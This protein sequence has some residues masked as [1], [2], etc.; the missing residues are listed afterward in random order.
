MAEQTIK[1]PAGKNREQRIRDPIVAAGLALFA[2]HPV[3]AVSID[4]I[5]G[6]AG[7]AKGSFYNHFANKEALL[8]A[9]VREIRDGIERDVAAANIEITDAARRV[10]RAICVYLRYVA[11]EPERGSVLVRNDRNGQTYASMSLSQG[12]LD[13]V[14]LG[15]R[16]GRFIVPTVDAGALFVLGVAHAGLMRFNGERVLG[17]NI[18][19][20]QQLCQ[21]ALRG[22]GVPLA[23]AELLSAQA[24][25][26]LLRPRA[27]S[28]SAQYTPRSGKP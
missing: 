24:A 27:G 15:L 13:D 3:D 26:D 18:A 16:E 17:G 9:V 6:A 14:A 11:D 10:V 21:L 22:L 7:V 1:R 28:S 4:D 25:D 2:E 8:A 23:E 5:V 12:T 19:M 20:A